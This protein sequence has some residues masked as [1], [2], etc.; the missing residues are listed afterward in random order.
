MAKKQ[1]TRTYYVSD[2]SDK[3]EIATT[4]VYPTGKHATRE[5]AEGMQ[6]EA[7]LPEFLGGTQTGV[8]IPVDPDY[9]DG[10]LEL[11]LFLTKGEEEFEITDMI[12]LESPVS[13]EI[14]LPTQE[15]IVKRI[16]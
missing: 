8:R 12:S 16:E 13:E 1:L 7:R 2:F 9:H 14:K 3:D 10:K 11:R 6:M 5:Q 4:A 15:Q